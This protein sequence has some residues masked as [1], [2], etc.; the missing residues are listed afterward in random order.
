ML[1]QFLVDKLPES[2]LMLKKHKHNLA[3]GLENFSLDKCYSLG[4]VLKD[5]GSL[6]FHNNPLLPNG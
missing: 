5:Q 3:N 6:C 2:T 1:V 4:E